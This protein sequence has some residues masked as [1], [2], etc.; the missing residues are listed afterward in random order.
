MAKEI[1]ASAVAGAEIAIVNGRPTR[2]DRADGDAGGNG[3]VDADD[4][5]AQGG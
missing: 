3:D 1:D 4:Q 2:R 5:Q